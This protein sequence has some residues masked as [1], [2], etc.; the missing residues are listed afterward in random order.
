MINFQ[1]NISLKP[2]T[3]FGFDVACRYFT[4]FNTDEELK[5]I[6]RCCRE[7]SL[8]WF[9]LGGG[10]NIIFSRDFDGVV[11]HPTADQIAV[12][13]GVVV[14]DAGLRWDD[15]VE[16]SVDNDLSGVENLSYIP[17]SVGASPVQNIGAYGAEVAQTIEYVECLDIETL[18]VTRIANCDCKFGYRESV[19]K[20]RLKGKVIVL[21]VAFKLSCEHHFNIEYGD[22]KQEVEKLGG[23]NLHNIRAAITKIRRQKLPDPQVEGNAGSFFKN[24]VIPAER[25]KLLLKTYPLMPHYPILDSRFSIFDEKIPAGWLIDTAGWRGFRRGDAG[26]HPRQALVLVN[27]GNAK[28]CDILELAND[29]VEDVET[30]FG[31]TLEMEVNVW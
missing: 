19:F 22:V 23:V 24:P 5:E 11:I 10:S 3:T 6:I 28:A 14:V 9:V 26:V 21:R 8:E 13:E 15:F 7:Q 16:W 2:L 31:I 17:G 29:I 18:E 12:K 27:Y 4:Q 20:N 25:V 1:Q 30:K